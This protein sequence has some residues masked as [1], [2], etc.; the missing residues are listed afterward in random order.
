MHLEAV[1]LE[2]A[3]VLVG[4]RELFLNC[5][6]DLLLALLVEL[7]IILVQANLDLSLVPLL[8]CGLGLLHEGLVLP[9]CLLFAG[10]GLCR[11]AGEVRGDDLEH[12]NYALLL[13]LEALVGG[14]LWNLTS[15]HEGAL[16]CIELSDDCQGLLHCLLA[17]LGISNGVNIL[18]VLLGAHLGGL[19]HGLSELLLL[20]HQRR[21]L[22]GHGVDVSSQFTNL[23]GQFALLLGLLVPLE[24]VCLQLLVA[25]SLVVGLSTGLCLELGQEVLDHC[26]DLGEGVVSNLGSKLGQSPRRKRSC[27]ALQELGSMLTRNGSRLGSLHLQE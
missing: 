20:V 16:A 11:Q 2:V 15:L 21:D 18:C 17:S 26:D 27:L 4:L 8:L 25:P 13:A 5:S 3:V 9:C 6:Q 14:H 24:L 10:S 7:S 19:L 12:A 23:C 1:W 22:L